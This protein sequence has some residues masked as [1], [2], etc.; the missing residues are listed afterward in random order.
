MTVYLS[1]HLFTSEIKTTGHGTAILDGRV[2]DMITQTDNDEYQNERNQNDQKYN[3]KIESTKALVQCNYIFILKYY[4][5][6]SKKE[7]ELIYKAESELNFKYPI[8]CS[9]KS[10][11]FRL[12]SYS[13]YSPA[14][15]EIRLIQHPICTNK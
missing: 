7:C 13:V 15:P 3:N 1:G 9:V 11:I 2:F 10:T 12:I 4:K 14:M 6:S 5:T 8:N